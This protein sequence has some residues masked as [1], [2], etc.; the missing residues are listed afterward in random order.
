MKQL[1]IVVIVLSSKLFAQNDSTKRIS[2]VGLNFNFN[3]NSTIN[4]SQEDFQ[5]LN[6]SNNSILNI[7]MSKYK[8]SSYGYT[9]SMSSGAGLICGLRFFPNKKNFITRFSLGVEENYL[10]GSHYQ[11]DS[12]E[13]LGHFTST[14]SSVNSNDVIAN[15]YKYVSYESKIINVQL[16]AAQLFYTKREKLFSFY[17]GVS[18]NISSSIQSRVVA[19]YNTGQTIYNIDSVTGQKSFGMFYMNNR[20]YISE[21]SKAK[22]IAY[23]GFGIPLG[24]EARL[25]KKRK[26][27]RQ[28][29]YGFEIMPTYNYL[30]TNVLA[31]QTF[32][33]IRLTPMH[34]TYR[35]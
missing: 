16:N 1:I 30:I 19:N 17:S 27:L 3:S 9:N 35:F 14:N 13:Y 34:L 15:N 32:F 2:F 4:G 10:M 26:V 11:N 33:S 24:L 20:I 8:H 25:S 5:Q 28:L 6:K 23:V 22:A 18:L 21:S 12:A 7:D 29:T 31:Q